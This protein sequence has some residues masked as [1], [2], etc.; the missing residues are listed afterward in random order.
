MYHSKQAHHRATKRKSNCGNKLS[1]QGNCKLYVDE[2][3]LKNGLLIKLV[4]EVRWKVRLTLAM[5]RYTNMYIM[6]RKIMV[7]CIS[8]LD[9][10]TG[11][12]AS[13]KIHI[14]IGD[15]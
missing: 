3:S 9:D 7:N 10:R 2:K 12:D 13:E 14:I 5:K 6:I 15:K 8:I 11:C 1:I 4:I